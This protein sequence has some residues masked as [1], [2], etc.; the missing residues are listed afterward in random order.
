MKQSKVVVI[1]YVLTSITLLIIG[2]G[3]NTYRVSEHTDKAIMRYMDQGN[4]AIVYFIRH[5]F[6][7]PH[8]VHEVITNDR[9]LGVLDRYT[10]LYAQLEPGKY[11]F[12]G[13]PAG[14]VR[15]KQKPFM[16]TVES[17]KIYYIKVDFQHDNL[18]FTQLS[19]KEGVEY[20]NKCTLSGVP[21]HIYMVIKEKRDSDEGLSNTI[22]IL[23]QIFNATED[24]VMAMEDVYVG[25]LLRYPILNYACTFKLVSQG[26]TLRFFKGDLPFD[27]YLNKEKILSMEEEEYFLVDVGGRKLAIKKNLVSY[28]LIDPPVKLEKIPYDIGEKTTTIELVG[29]NYKFNKKIIPH[30]K[31]L[32]DQKIV[33]CQSESLNLYELSLFTEDNL[34]NVITFSYIP[35]YGYVSSNYNYNFIDTYD[36][37]MNALSEK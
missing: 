13:H 31:I 19:K 5:E 15:T 3:K 30:P 18:K 23:S 1:L 21:A 34:S 32:K 2:C 10:Y 16:L 7:G 28:Y 8:I 36:Q 26:E 22:K 11:E 9:S 20:L 35:Y 25:K 27:V 24:Q 37:F 33:G 14:W 6:I 12:W 4:K 17:K 29:K